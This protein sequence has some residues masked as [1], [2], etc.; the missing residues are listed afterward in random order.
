MRDRAGK[1]SVQ[2][3]IKLENNRGKVK[4]QAPRKK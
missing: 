2:T 1:T 4:Q 3:E